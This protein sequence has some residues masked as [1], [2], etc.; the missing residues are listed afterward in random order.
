MT[1][2]LPHR[3]AAPPKIFGRLNDFPINSHDDDSLR[4]ESL[5]TALAERIT[6]YHCVD[7]SGDGCDT[8]SVDTLGIFGS[9]GT[10]KSSILALT[11]AKCGEKV[12]W[13]DFDAL[14]Y[15]TEELILVPLMHRL[16]EACSPDAAPVFWKLIKRLGDFAADVIVST[17][18]GPVTDQVA[19]LI[20]ATKRIPGELSPSADLPTSRAAAIESA[21]ASLIRLFRKSDPH[22]R[23]VIAIDNLDRCRPRA[24]LEML[25]A[26]HLLL[27]VNNVTFVLAMDQAACVRCISEAYGFSVSESA[28]YLEKMIPDYIRVPDPWVGASY[29]KVKKK[30][31]A[32]LQ[33]LKY[34]FADYTCGSISPKEEMLWEVIGST[35]ILRNP[36]RIKRLIRRMTSFSDAWLKSHSDDYLAVLFLC[37]VSDIWPGLYSAIPVAESSEWKKF[38]EAAEENRISHTSLDVYVDPSFLELILALSQWDKDGTGFDD[39]RDYDT[40]NELFGEVRTLG[41]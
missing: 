18:G 7:C 21:F 31:D 17:Y 14:K 9:W 19:K 1:T 28:L 40:M 39:I 16:A 37:A 2:P 33:Y 30:P 12:L 35:T 10:G 6:G 36:R 5:I 22:K 26:I 34:L 41:L 24:L 15:Q 20:E 27:G 4:F 29:K 11:K 13:L 8:R 32:I 23:V 38:I 3:F 25:E